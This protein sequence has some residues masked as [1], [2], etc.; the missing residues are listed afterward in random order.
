MAF[1]WNSHYSSTVACFGEEIRAELRKIETERSFHP[2]LG[3]LWNRFSRRRTKGSERKEIH[4]GAIWKRTR[5]IF[6]RGGLLSFYTAESRL[7]SRGLRFKAPTAARTHT[8]KMKYPSSPS[9]KYRA[10]AHSSVK[11]SPDS[12]LPSSRSSQSW[13][14]W[15]IR[16]GLRVNLFFS[17]YFFFFFRSF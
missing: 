14:A 12:P 13:T 15:R 5:G 6:L 10:V 17:F 4:R 3:S 9:M 16:I 1:H 7:E 11:K 8:P 2:R